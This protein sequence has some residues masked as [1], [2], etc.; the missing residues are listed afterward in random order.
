LL[1]GQIPNDRLFKTISPSFA[2][3]PAGQFKFVLG[4]PTA[5]DIEA[6]QLQVSAPS[7]E[8]MK[9]NYDFLILGTGSQTKGDTPFKSTG[10]TEDAV[11]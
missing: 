4:S 10:S 8:E 1:P 9:L 7:D 6:R 5:I 2:H 3:Y 11:H